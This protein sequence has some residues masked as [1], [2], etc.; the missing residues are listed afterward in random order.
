MWGVDKLLSRSGTWAKSQLP[1]R[2]RVNKV[3]VRCFG[4]P[5]SPSLSPVSYSHTLEMLRTPPV[6]YAKEDGDVAEAHK[7]SCLP[8][9]ELG[10][11]TSQ[12]QDHEMER[13]NGEGC[14][15]GWWLHRCSLED[16]TLNLAGGFVR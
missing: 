16:H 2:V 4:H 1:A 5:S 8:H 10:V 13:R 3:P 14:G 7:P 6:T 9:P 15:G 11:S 12:S